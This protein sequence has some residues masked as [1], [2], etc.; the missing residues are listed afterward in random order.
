MVGAEADEVVGGGLPAV[1]PVCDVVDFADCV[2]A[3]GESALAVVSDGDCFAH[4]QWDDSF[5]GG[6]RVEV[7]AWVE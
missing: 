5:E 4:R 6:D 2:S 3:S 1:L 7:S